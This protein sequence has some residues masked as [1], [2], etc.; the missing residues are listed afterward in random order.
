MHKFREDFSFLRHTTGIY[1]DSASTALKPDVVFEAISNYHRYG[2]SN[3]GRSNHRYASVSTQLYE[4][5]REQVAKFI[6]CASDEVLFT[7]N[8]TDAINLAASALALPDTSHVVVSPY[9]HHSNL[10][11][12]RNKCRTSTMRLLPDGSIDLDHLDE[13]MS[14]T[15][16]RLV[17]LCHASNVTGNIQ[18]ASEITAIAHSHGALCL[19]DAAQTA[20]HISI[21]VNQIGCDF[22]A[23]AP[24]KFLAPSGTGILYAR[25]DIQ[26]DMTCV[27]HGGG[28]VNRVMRDTVDYA[29]GPARFEAGTP[30]ID[31]IIG[32]GAA[33]DY[34]T[35]VSLTSIYQHDR[36]LDD[37]LQDRLQSIEHVIPVFARAAE[38]V[39]VISLRPTGNVD[40]AVIARL[41]SDRYSIALSSGYQCNQ[42]LYRSVGI[43][44]GLRVS[45]HL[46]NTE[47]DIDHLIDALNDLKPLMA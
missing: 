15:P 18:P 22:L 39:P 36:Q 25:R 7:A 1:L 3:V 45:L 6:N 14:Q 33:I 13:L 20:G 47:S 5:V 42:I 9:E 37:Y 43:D 19:I 24:H 27:R 35:R 17:A 21:D 4:R 40:I 28:I 8:C 11:P 30:N 46:Y 10:L 23:L 34:L 29:T 2:A 41:L 31:G 26:A 12:W 44:G 16:T 38:R 32:L